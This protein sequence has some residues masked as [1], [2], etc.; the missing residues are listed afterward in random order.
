MIAHRHWSAIQ[1]QRVWR[2]LLGRNKAIDARKRRLAGASG[3]S[4]VAF[5]VKLKVKATTAVVWSSLIILIQLAISYT[6]ITMC[7]LG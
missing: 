6:L 5:I 1:I 3:R 4:G 2:G 7:T